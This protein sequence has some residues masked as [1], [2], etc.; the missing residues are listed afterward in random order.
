MTRV[1]SL[2]EA[3]LID[4]TPS[5]TSVQHQMILHVV[6]STMCTTC[7]IIPEGVDDCGTT[8]VV[9]FVVKKVRRILVGP[10]C[11]STELSLDCQRLLP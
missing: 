8:Q 11:Q 9:T 10:C 6:C 3:T 2:T 4:D 7:E 5:F 1:V